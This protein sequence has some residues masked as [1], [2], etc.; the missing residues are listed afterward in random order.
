MADGIRRHGRDRRR[1]SWSAL[2]G[3]RCPATIRL[4]SAGDMRAEL[5]VLLSARRSSTRSRSRCSARARCSRSS[6]TSRRSCAAR[7]HVS[8]GFVTGDARALRSSASRVGNW[9]GGR[10]ADRALDRT[11]ITVLVALT[12]LL[13]LFAVTMPLAAARGRCR[14]SRGA[15]RHSRSCAPV[16]MRVMAVGV[17]THPTLAS[18]I[19]IGAFNLGNARGCRG[20]RRRD[21]ARPRLSRRYRWPARCSRPWR[22][23]LVLTTRT[24]P[25]TVSAAP[26]QGGRVRLKRPPR[27]P[28]VR[29]A[30]TTGSLTP[31]VS[32]SPGAP[33]CADAR[34]ARRGPRGWPRRA[35]EAAVEFAEPRRVVHL[36]ALAFTADQARLA[37]H[38]EVLRQRRLGYPRD[39]STSRNAEQVWAH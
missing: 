23:V 16:Q 8:N 33:P 15:S 35:G 5:R 37:Q 38:L 6:R 18:S 27:R 7:P 1:R 3:S 30:T 11:L 2:C 28:V 9:L 22:L 32:A 10:F 39:R 12:V 25:V 17:T 13:L 19:N 29:D 36:H 4:A 34:P 24:P 26:R 31:P 14:S 20:R 21:R